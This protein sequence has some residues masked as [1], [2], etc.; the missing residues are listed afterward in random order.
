MSG[1][2]SAGDG[3]DVAQHFCVLAL[4]GVLLL[5]ECAVRELLTKPIEGDIDDHFEAYGALSA[6]RLS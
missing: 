5:L 1:R 6:T 3:V 2:K 4:P